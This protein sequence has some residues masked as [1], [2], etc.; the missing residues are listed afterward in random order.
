MNGST[1]TIEGGYLI[2]IEGIDG[3]GKTTLATALHAALREHGIQAVLTKE[4]TK[5]PFGQRIRESAATGRLQP[6]EELELL[7]ADRREHV[8][9][10]LQP[11]L[12]TGK[13][14]ILDRYYLSNIAYQGSEGLDMQMILQRNEEFAPVPNLVFLLDIAPALGLERIASR[15]DVA[16]HF[17]N[18]KNLSACRSYFQSL[19]S[20]AWS[21]LEG[22]QFVTIDASQSPEDVLAIALRSFVKAVCNSVADRLGA[23]PG[24]ADEVL[25]LLGGALVGEPA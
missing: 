4:P 16:N 15:G 5:G 18:E 12:A 7:I 23:T 22:T 19:A 1:G 13:V 10:L 9:L 8:E 25:R 20:G 14:V 17:E 11:S 2:A 3:A 6:D 24:G 21:G